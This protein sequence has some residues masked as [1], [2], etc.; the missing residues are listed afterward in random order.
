M[1][2]YIRHFLN[3]TVLLGIVAA[4]NYAPLRAQEEVDSLSS[5][6][7]AIPAQRLVIHPLSLNNL[8]DRIG[9]ILDSRI[10]TIIKKNGNY[11]VFSSD[12]VREILRSQNLSTQ[13][14]C[15]TVDCLSTF[16]FNTGAEFG[17]GGEIRLL[18]NGYLFDLNLV[19]VLQ[20]K[21]DESC[22]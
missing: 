9:R 21:T 6:P 1:R 22:F 3:W 4:V 18:P 5:I 17:I 10:R 14:N 7:I 11:F 20:K 16:G 15:N 13:G 19:G 8:S 12:Q 2:S